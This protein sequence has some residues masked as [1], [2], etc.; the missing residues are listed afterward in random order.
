MYKRLLK[1]NYMLN[2]HEIEE[3]QKLKNVDYYPSKKIAKLFQKKMKIMKR[4]L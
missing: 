2:Q 1:I 4:R 3:E